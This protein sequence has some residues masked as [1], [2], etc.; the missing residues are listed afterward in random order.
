MQ[1]DIRVFV[2]T[3][4]HAGRIATPTVLSHKML[5]T[6]HHFQRFDSVAPEAH[7]KTEHV[8]HQNLKTIQAEPIPASTKP[9]TNIDVIAA[10]RQ[11]KRKKISDQFPLLP[12]KI[13][14]EGGIR[15]RSSHSVTS[16]LM[17]I[18]KGV[19]LVGALEISNNFTDYIQALESTYRRNTC[20]SRCCNH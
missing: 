17:P 1:P 19:V 10:R 3:S 11:P 13:I 20:S 12:L 8:V 6:F 7:A 4:L 2:R 18:Q 15:K 9:K 14:E 16:V 5:S